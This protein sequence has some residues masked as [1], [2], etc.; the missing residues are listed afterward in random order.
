MLILCFPCLR[1]GPNY[2]PKEL[3]YIE[4]KIWVLFFKNVFNP[5]KVKVINHLFK[6]L[7]TPA[8]AKIFPWRHLEFR[9]WKERTGERK[10]FIESQAFGLWMKV[11]QWYNKGCEVVPK[12]NL[13]YVDIM[14]K[15]VT[16]EPEKTI[17]ACFT[18]RLWKHWLPFFISGNAKRL[19]FP[20]L[21][22]C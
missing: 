3:K 12:A 21:Y 16:R 10:W 11:A 7:C 9:N 20:E 22:I 14:L 15:E 13:D 2:F 6:L 8:P 1:P 4:T 17:T 18:G 5:E 19:Y